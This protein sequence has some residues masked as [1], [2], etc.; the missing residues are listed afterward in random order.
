MKL[1]AGPCGGDVLDPPRALELGRD[2]GVDLGEG[3]ARGGGVEGAAGLVRELLQRLLGLVARADRD[4]VDQRACLVG[5][6]DRLVERG[7][8]RDVLA[9]GEEHDHARPARFLREDARRERHGV[10]Q[11]RAGGRVHG[12][13]A[14]RVVG[15]DRRGGEARQ[16]HGLRAEDDHGDAVG[17]RL[18]REELPRSRRR[19]LQLLAG[20]RLRAVDGDHDALRGGEVLCG[21]VDHAAAVLGQGR[22]LVG[23]DRRDEGR[24]DRRIPAH[25]DPTEG[26]G[27]ARRHRRQEGDDGGEEQDADQ[28]AAVHSNPP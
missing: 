3:L 7:L 21:Q 18:G 19:V 14:Q 23:G 10:V 1:L 6:G 9:V 26:H 27:R 22:R 17:R 16:L 5:A 8:A 20:H 4:R 25:V 11:R 2:R 24:A 15:V 13:R 12:H 28:R